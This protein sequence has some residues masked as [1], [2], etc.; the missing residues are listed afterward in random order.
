MR[1]LWS[2]DTI[3]FAGEF[4]RVTGAGLNPRPIQRPIP[5]WYGGESPVAY[6][7]AGRIADGWI[8][9]NKLP[10]EAPDAAKA[11]VEKAAVEAGRD[12]ATLGMQ[13][14]VKWGKDGAKF[15]LDRMAE[16][17]DAWRESGATHVAINTM[18]ADLKSPEEHLAVLTDVAGA[19]G[20]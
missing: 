14:R 7:R 13:G 8:P 20:L 17:V 11:I 18:Y 6:R 10:G 19:L 5:V 12:P 1:K 16:L 15:S 2:E 3:T 4:D 9:D